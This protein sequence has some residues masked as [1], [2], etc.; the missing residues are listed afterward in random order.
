[1]RAALIWLAL[2]G[3]ASEGYALPRHE[4]APYMPAYGG[5]P[6]P[7]AWTG[8]LHCP[9]PWTD[10]SAAQIGSPP[11]PPVAAAPPAKAVKRALA[12]ISS[13]PPQ[14]KPGAFPLILA[15]R[16][17][18]SPS[19]HDVLVG[20]APEPAP[21]LPPQP[22]VCVRCH[23][24]D[25]KTSNSLRRATPFIAGQVQAGLAQL[26]KIATTSDLRE[27]LLAAGHPAETVRK[28]LVSI[29]QKPGK[30]AGRL[31]DIVVGA[32]I[33]K[34]SVV[35]AV[36]VCARVRGLH[37]ARAMCDIRPCGCA[38]VPGLR[39]RPP[40]HPARPRQDPGTACTARWLVML[41]PG[42]MCVCDCVSVL[43]VRK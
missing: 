38:E 3:H 19:L 9:R 7:R 12:T 41:A 26:T 15:L 23:Q 43:F 32:L 37:P 18:P 31:K 14:L 17:M 5:T 1:M 2:A 35:V 21:E 22:K 34:V 39:L 8:P 25:K 20:A 27:A 16:A 33:H 24:V 10:T 6:S 28:L 42:C 40:P 11:P 13:S 29:H 36:F 30:Y 4:Y